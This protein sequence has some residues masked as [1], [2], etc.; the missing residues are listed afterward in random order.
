MKQA[1]SVMLELR[2]LKHGYGIAAAD[3]R[4]WPSSGRVEPAK[5]KARIARLDTL[6]EVGFSRPAFSRISSF[7]QI[8]EP[9]HDA[10][11]QE[12]IIPSDAIRV[13]NGNTIDSSVVSL[14]L[15]SPNCVM[16][17]RLNGY[18][19]HFSEIRNPDD[20]ECAKKCMRRFESAASGFLQD[21]RPALWKLRA[22][23]WLAVEGGTNATEHMIR[24]LTWRPNERD[25]FE[26]G[27]TA[28][29][30]VAKFDSSNEEEVWSAGVHLDKSAIPEADLFLDVYSEYGSGSSYV[31]F[32]DKAEHIYKIVNTVCEKLGLI[33]EWS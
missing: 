18:R 7:V 33:L 26:I 24:Q 11:I 6:Y 14:N 21:G 1:D 3:K 2:I 27:A 8:I 25:P 4:L 12:L 13:E 19:A 10:L 23:F 28:T 31:S 16:E 22:P 20:L 15:A 30:S 9:I 32:D 5:M 29:R 17:A